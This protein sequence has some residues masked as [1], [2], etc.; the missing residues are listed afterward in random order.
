[1]LLY[2]WFVNTID[3]SWM[4]SSYSLS[5]NEWDVCFMQYLWY[6]FI[7]KTCLISL[8]QL[9]L[10][11][12]LLLGVLLIRQF[13]LSWFSYLNNM[14]IWLL[15][16]LMWIDLWQVPEM[17]L[18]EKSDESA[19]ILLLNINRVLCSLLFFFFKKGQLIDMS[20]GSNP[21]SIERRRIFLIV[22]D[23]LNGISLAL[24]YVILTIGLSLF[25]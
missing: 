2:L 3:S 1:M 19:R 7:Y 11:T 25:I 9:I 23:G 12:S 15:S 22:K 20:M 16:R 5:F 24:I 6:F 21:K 14:K 18:W 8:S 17:W 10:L 13:C 4:H